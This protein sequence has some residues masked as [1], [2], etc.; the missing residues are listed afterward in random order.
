M[1]GQV[2]AFF[3]RSDRA[4]ARLVSVDTTTAKATDGVLA[5]FTGADLANRSFGNITPLSPPPGRNGQKIMAPQR[6]VIARERVRFVGEEVAL[7]IAESADAARDAADLI[8]IEYEDLPPIISF[9]AALSAEAPILH[10]N[11]PGNICFDFEYGNEQQ[12]QLAFDRAAGIVELTINSPRVAPTPME[13]RGALVRYDAETESFDIYCASQGASAFRHELAILAGIETERLRV[14][15]VDVGGAFGARTGPFPEYPV[16]MYASKVLGRPVKWLSTRSEDFLTDNHGRAITIRGQLA[17]DATGTFIA[18]RTDWLC[19]SGAYLTSAGVLT[20]SVNG[21]SI[22]A[23]IYRIGAFYGRHRQVMTN[24]APTNA[25]RGAGR[26]E[27]VYIVERLVDQAA[28]RLDWDP[29]DLRLHNAIQP[30]QMPYRTSTGTLLDSGDFPALICQARTRSEWDRF[31]ERRARSSHRGKLRGRGCS[32]FFEPA[33]GGHVPVDEIAIQFERNGTVVLHCTA[34]SSGQGH[35]TV[36]P[37]MVEK[38]LGLPENTVVL[39]AGDPNGPR[40]RGNPSIGS[41][42]GMLLGSAFKAGADIVLTK[43]KSLAAE[44]LE[45]DTR[46]V[47]FEHGTFRVAGTDRAVTLTDL[48]ERNHADNAHPL[49]TIAENPV[50]RSFPCGAHI[51]EVEIDRATGAVDIVSYCAVDDIGNV[52]NQTI[53]D[54]Q[55]FGGIV[56]GA[57]QVFGECCLYDQ[58]DGQ[59]LTG[60]FMDYVMPRA[61]LIT[62]VSLFTHVEPTPN[63]LLGAKGVGETGTTGAISACMNA[64]VDALRHLDID[65]CEMPV[66]SYRLWR[67]INE[68]ETRIANSAMGDALDF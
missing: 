1:E 46:D 21:M 35:E 57:G 50:T 13:P 32:V 2:F 67:L 62:D 24:T 12:T 17:Y 66:T 14:Q 49:D 36:F 56:Q 65:H 41:R 11:V 45:A 23:G 68:A 4:H 28:A 34:G 19:D 16:L 33:G 5:V 44:A 42:S 30:E 29:L 22:G 9:D 55:I 54:G 3:R 48:I 43:A 51:V 26:P 53:A 60:S 10:P 64:I 20:N 47:E 38:W 18:L 39:R 8:E 63:N 7:V 27:A 15:M 52:L 58:K 61:Q 25:Y 31:P 37:E 59:L 6:P 40:I